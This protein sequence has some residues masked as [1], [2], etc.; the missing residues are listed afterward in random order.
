MKYDVSVV[1]GGS[2]GAI[3]AARLTEDHSKSVLLI[4]AGPD[5]PDFDTMPNSLK[6]GYAQNDTPVDHNWQ[7]WG[8]ATDSSKLM[9]VPR[10]KVTGGSGAI[11]GQI[12]LR[13]VPED[14]DLWA[15]QGNSEWNFNRL[16]PYFRMIESDQD[17]PDKEYHSSSGKTV[18]RRYSPDEIRP[19]QEAFKEACLAAGFPFCP[20]QNAPDASGVGPVPINNL[21]GVRLSTALDYLNPARHR[22]NLTVRPDCLT[23]RILFDGTH[24]VGLEVESDGEIFQVYGKKIILSAGVIG[25]PHLLLLS[26]IGPK[27]QLEEKNIAIVNDLSGVGQNL[28]DHPMV[29]ILWDTLPD[30]NLDPVAPRVQMMHRWTASESKH[31]NDLVIYMQSYATHRT[32]PSNEQLEPVGIRMFVSVHYGLGRGYLRLASSDP[33]DHPILNYRYFSHPE[34]MRRMREGV[35]IAVGLGKQE[36]FQGIINSRID[37]TDDQLSDDHK[38]NQYIKKVVTTGQHSS[39]TCKMGPISDRD[40]VVD[41]YGKVHGVENLRI[42]DASIMPHCIRANTEATTRMIAER[43]CQF[44]L[45][46][47]TK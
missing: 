6:D 3:V 29:P 8:Q 5:Y 11:N 37:P 43:I 16:I 23:R 42:I 7:F 33:H 2:A 1:G 22:I 46:G 47:S 27:T 25:S 38:L 13:G 31:R 44:L 9:M 41:Q 20:D 15:D 32:S 40:S 10:G 34:D 26:G 39:G 30:F 21:D 4:E 28:G 18:V 17:F 36:S 24:A 19:D 45:D 12:F 14:Y 35:R